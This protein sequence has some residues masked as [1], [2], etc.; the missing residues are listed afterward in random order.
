MNIRTIF[1]AILVSHL[2]LSL[3][4]MTCFAGYPMGFGW[5]VQAIGGTQK[6]KP[7]Y[8]KSPLKIE[9]T[10]PET[11]SIPADVSEQV[12]L[13][14]AFLK[15]D[16]EWCEKALEVAKRLQGE[17]KAVDEKDG[18]VTA[19]HFVNAA[20]GSR[21]YSSASFGVVTNPIEDHLLVHFDEAVR[22]ELPP[23]PRYAAPPKTSLG[24][25]FRV[26]N[27]SDEPIELPKFGPAMCVNCEIKLTGSGI[28]SFKQ[29]RKLY[30]PALYHLYYTTVKPGESFDVS[31]RDTSRAVSHYNVYETITEPG[32]V[33][34]QVKVTFTT[35][36]GRKIEVQLD[37]KRTQAQ[38]ANTK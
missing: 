18:K 23:R 33:E 2:V 19:K 7:P 27:I 20:R 6:A 4:A 26:T 10:L 13:Y 34:V 37:S 1:A 29:P 15:A 17:S 14:K 5:P 25:K 21:L 9:F 3:P 30:G 24:M 36:D 35:K 38:L 11:V 28:M 12:R 22:N 31:V 32:S 16:R 8:E